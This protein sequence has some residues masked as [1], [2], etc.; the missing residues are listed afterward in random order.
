[1]RIRTGFNAARRMTTQMLNSRKR[2]T[3]LSSAKNS[4]LSNRLSNS[5]LTSLN[6]SSAQ[7]A[8]LA[9]IGY[10]RLQ[11]SANSLVEGAK[12]LGQKVDAGAGDVSAAA[13]DLVKNYNETMKYLRESSGVLNDFYRQSLKETVLTNRTELEEIGFTVGSDGLLALNKEKL[14]AADGDKVKRLLGA[15]GDLAGRI[16]AVASR[17]ADNARVNAENVSSKYTASGS[18]ASSYLSKYNFWG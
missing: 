6:A 18:L 8:Q 16:S 2:K 10:E 14:A 9:R 4:N 11:K 17:A 5:R 3:G 1:M 13:E 15:S 7:S 12:L